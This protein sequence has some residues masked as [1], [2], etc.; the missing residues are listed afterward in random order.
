MSFEA[1]LFKVAADTQAIR[2][3]VSRLTREE[4]AR[5]YVVLPQPK[6]REVPRDA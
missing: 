5:L 4:L 2:R 6:L 3:V 1:A